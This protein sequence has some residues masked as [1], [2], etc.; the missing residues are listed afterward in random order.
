MAGRNNHYD[1]IVVGAGSGGLGMSG[2]ANA[3]GLKTL[4]IEQREKNI[5]GDCLNYGCVP[6]K[7]LIHISKHFS[8]AVKASRFGLDIKGKA[9][10]SKVLTY[11]KEKQAV[12]RHHEN[13]EYLRDQGIDVVIG[14]AKFSSPTDI[15]VSGNRYTATKIVLAT[16][17]RPRHLQFA[18]LNQ[19]EWYNNETLFYEMKS[20]PEKLLVLGGGPIGCEMAQAFQRLGS[21]VTIVNSG[22]SLLQR[23]RPEISQILTERFQLEGIIVHNSSKLIQFPSPHE[24]EVLT[25]Q[26]K[27]HVGLDAALIAIGRVI[28]TEGMG[29]EKAGIKVEDGRILVD[30]YLRTTNRKVYAVGDA[31]GMYK[32]SHGAEKHVRL[33]SRNFFLPF[34]KKHHTQDLSWVTFTDPEVATFG[35]TEEDLQRN[36]LNY[37]RQDQ[38]LNSDDRA[39]TDSYT[40]GRMSLFFTKQRWWR[41]PRLLGGTLIAPGAG[42][43]IQELLLATNAG[44]SVKWIFDKVYPYPTASRINQKN[45]RGL[46]EALLTPFLKRVLRILYRWLG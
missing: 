20:L 22:L 41:Q 1:I 21:K 17:S 30:N 26:G 45:V 32:F 29:L 19:V 35:M 40:Y 36:G 27:I 3:I 43:I 34:R 39:I 25:K 44:L 6:S 31:A 7:A 10:I 12:I 5:G 42:E 2:V 14:R 28:N 9:D 15:D 38:D 23:E 16:G 13:A 46:R 11:V 24:A 4:L 18:G 37:W 8:H 33:L